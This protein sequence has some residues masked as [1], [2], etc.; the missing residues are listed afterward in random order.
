M[1]D[2][3]NVPERI[4]GWV[5]L[6]KDGSVSMIHSTKEKA[7]QERRIEINYGFVNHVACKFIS[8]T[9]GEGLE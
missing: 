3:I 6:Y 2:L 8:F 9:A 5:H 7:D 4:E 1:T